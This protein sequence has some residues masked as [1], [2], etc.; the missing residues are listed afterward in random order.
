MFSQYLWLI[1][2]LLLIYTASAEPAF[3]Q[4]AAGQQVLFA[5]QVKQNIQRL[6][7]GQEA[8]V[9]VKLNDRTVLGGYVSQVGADS[10]TLIERKTN[11]TVTVPY[12]Q[13]KQISGGNRSTGIHFSI[14][15]PKLTGAPPK[16]LK[17]VAIGVGFG[18]G[19]LS[20][21]RLVTSF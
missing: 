1:P 9:R 14:P 8:R 18:F 5:E 15:G 13:V 17:G 20:F 16:L 21:V 19:I 12:A 6:G 10:F 7:V 2:A 11:A 3:A 4:S